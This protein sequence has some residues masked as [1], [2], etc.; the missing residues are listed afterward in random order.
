M[1]A[2]GNRFL[3]F[4]AETFATF[5]ADRI[6]TA[7]L[8]TDI[9]AILVAVGTGIVRRCTI[10]LSTHPLTQLPTEVVLVLTAFFLLYTFSLVILSDRLFTYY[11][12]RKDVLFIKDDDIKLAYYVNQG[13]LDPF[14]FCSRDEIR[15]NQP[16]PSGSLYKCGE[17]GF[18][19]RID[20]VTCHNLD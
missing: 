18:E 4:L 19:A 17:C 20:I 12:I 14:P 6:L 15:L 2:K 3:R 9:L 16:D 7:V 11:R 5:V 10:E 1:K 13:V 8:S